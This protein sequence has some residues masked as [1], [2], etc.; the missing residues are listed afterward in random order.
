MELEKGDF[1]KD[2]FRSDYFEESPSNQRRKQL[3]LFNQ[4]S[5]SVS[6]GED[7]VNYEL[8]EKLKR[9]KEELD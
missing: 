4:R 1:R 6:T 8:Q 7:K 2:S 3:N 9:M 5:K